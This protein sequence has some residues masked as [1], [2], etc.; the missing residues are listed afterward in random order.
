MKDKGL[1]PNPGF[2][3]VENKLN[4]RRTEIF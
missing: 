1:K 4:S 2:S 3:W